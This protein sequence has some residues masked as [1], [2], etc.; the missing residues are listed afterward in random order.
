MSR[1]A[2]TDALHYRGQ[3]KNDHHVAHGK[4]GHRT[5]LRA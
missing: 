5:V 1:N 3:V 4:R 2:V